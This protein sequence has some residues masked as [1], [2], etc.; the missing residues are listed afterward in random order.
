[1]PIATAIPPRD[2][3][4]ADKPKYDMIINVIAIEIGM[5]INTRKVARKFIKNKASTM[6]I[7]INARISDSTTVLTAFT[8][9][10]D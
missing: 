1:M 7:K 4:F 5:E 10:S 2:I 8:I 9:K 6:A 3:R